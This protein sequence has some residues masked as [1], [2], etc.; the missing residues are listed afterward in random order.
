MNPTTLKWIQRHWIE[1]NDID[2]I[3][4]FQT[5]QPCK[6]LQAQHVLQGPRAKSKTQERERPKRD[7]VARTSPHRDFLIPRSPSRLPSGDVKAKNRA[8]GHPCPWWVD[9][10]A[11]LWLT[12]GVGEGGGRP[13]R[14]MLTWAATSGREG[15]RSAGSFSTL[16]VFRM[17]VGLWVLKRLS[18]EKDL[19]W[20]WWYG[21]RVGVNSGHYEIWKWGGEGRD[22]RTLLPPPLPP[23]HV[24]RFV[25]RSCMTLVV[26]FPPKRRS[27]PLVL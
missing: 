10:P 14:G 1:S 5:N 21:G 8:L 17:E 4:S 20:Q 25:T 13:W 7:P 6:Q 22:A 9:T 26:H 16:A 12:A 23:P 19:Q 24:V 15:E 27:R 2:T 3:F 18:I 11:R